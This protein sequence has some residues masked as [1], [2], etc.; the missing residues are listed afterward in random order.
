[1]PRPRKQDGTETTETRKPRKATTETLEHPASALPV[2]LLDLPTVAQRLCVSR[3]KV[4]SLINQDGLP[5]IKIGK[6]FRV[7]Q[8][9]LNQ[10]VQQREQQQVS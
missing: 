6:V 7:S 5:A 8:S 1:M 9:S 4:Y 3:V 2:Q 10:W